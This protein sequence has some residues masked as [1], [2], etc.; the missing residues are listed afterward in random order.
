MVGWFRRKKQYLFSP[1]VIEKVSSH[2]KTE[3]KKILT[4]EICHIFNGKINKNSLM[5]VDEGAA[6]LLSGQK[7]NNDL[8]KEDL[9]LFYNNFF[10]KNIGLKLFSKNKGYK[11]SYWTIKTIVK[12]FNRKKI[13]ELIKI[14]PK[15]KYCKQKIEKVLK[16]PVEEFLER[17]NK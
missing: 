10:C 4:H 7:K 12:M 15:T 1:L 14:N 3:I 11:I 16:L 8:T 13:L 2:K 9:N 17:I 6:L 5:W